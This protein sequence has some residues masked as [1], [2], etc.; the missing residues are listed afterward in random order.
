LKRI[1]R[2]D[3]VTRRAQEACA[4]WLA[5]C[6]RLGWSKAQLDDL[7]TM[8]WQHHDKRGELTPNNGSSGG[9]AVH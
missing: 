3:G 7:E 5:E 8:W 1:V 6:I 2:P 4:H 9:E